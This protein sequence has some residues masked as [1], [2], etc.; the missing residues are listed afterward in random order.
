MQGETIFLVAACAPGRH[1]KY[2]IVVFSNQFLLLDR[3]KTSWVNFQ[4]SVTKTRPSIL[5]H[6]RTGARFMLDKNF[7]DLPK[8]EEKFSYI[9]GVPDGNYSE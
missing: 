4:P 5:S 7:A 6:Q 2:R 3:K 9:I 1:F 8:N